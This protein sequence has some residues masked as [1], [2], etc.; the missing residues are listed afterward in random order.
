MSAR[1]Q[2]RGRLQGSSTRSIPRS[3]AK[4]A[5]DSREVQLTKFVILIEQR[6]MPVDVKERS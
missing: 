3:R 4:S 2:R 5:H 1:E 6:H